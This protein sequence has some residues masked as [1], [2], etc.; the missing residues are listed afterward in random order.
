MSV[1]DP[2]SV[3]PRERET[4]AKLYLT[5][6]ELLAR[7]GLSPATLQRYKAAGR[8]PFFQPGGRGGRVL[9]PPD[10][11][12]IARALYTET[13]TDVPPLAAVPRKRPGPPP[14][15]RSLET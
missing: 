3:G 13:K 12:E 11:I 2:N 8:I 15:W 7:T 4:D 5:R 6:E 10:A 1:L 14:K 9:F